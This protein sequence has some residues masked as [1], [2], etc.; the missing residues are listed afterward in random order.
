MVEALGG[1]AAAQPGQVFVP[2]D[3]YVAENV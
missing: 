2:F 3:L 1:P